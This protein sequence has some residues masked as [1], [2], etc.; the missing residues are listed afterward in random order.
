MNKSLLFIVSGL[1][2]TVAGC[3]EQQ[4]NTDA[5]VVE[6]I[7]KYKIPESWVQNRV[8]KANKRLHAT[9]AGKVVWKSMEAH[10]GL[11]KW[12]SNGYLSFRFNYQPLDG[13][14]PRDTYQTIDTWSNKARHVN[15]AD[16]TA[17]FGWDGE[18]AWVKAKDSTAFKYNMRFWALTPI[19][20]AAQ[21]L[22]LDGE[23][24]NLELLPGIEYK[25]VPQDVVKVTFVSGTGDAPDDYYILYLDAKTHLLSALRYIV[26]YPGYFPNG[27]NNPE[28]F[29]ELV[30]RK[31]INGITLPLKFNTFWSTSGGQPKGEPVTTI[32]LSRIE[33]QNQLEEDFFK[34]PNG[35]K[36]I[37]GL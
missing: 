7:S 1:L 17:I 8:D 33:F 30:S 14:E 27:G 37:E 18:N 36:L 13:S 25:G 32:E 19:Y 12:Y 11:Y 31:T 4:K 10:G 15:V 5:V 26:S 24:V 20:L 16:S 29:M 9:E 35:A 2:L 22:V 28:K 34:R 3:K 21:P 6:S 23:G